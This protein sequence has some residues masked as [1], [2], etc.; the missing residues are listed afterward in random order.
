MWGFQTMLM[1]DFSSGV[2]VAQWELVPA[3]TKVK[4]DLLSRKTAAFV[5]QQGTSHVRYVRASQRCSLCYQREPRHHLK[6]SPDSSNSSGERLQQ[7][8]LFTNCK[9]HWTRQ[10]KKTAQIFPL[11]D[12]SFYLDKF[13][14]SSLSI[15]QL[16]FATK[17][18]RTPWDPQGQLGYTGRVRPLNRNSTVKTSIIFLQWNTF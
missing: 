6:L 12:I 4:R 17:L 16:P 13:S 5:T 9:P 14:G 1:L 2:G 10:N 15:I 3:I 11:N 18:T 7:W 8:G